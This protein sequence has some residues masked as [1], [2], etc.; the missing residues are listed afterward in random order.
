[1]SSDNRMPRL[2]ELDALRGVA[3]LCV[4]GF[5]YTF[6]LPRFVELET[7]PV[8]S[9][10]FGYF[11]VELFFMIS[12]FVILLTLEKTVSGA[13]FIVARFSRLYPVFWAACLT[14]FAIGVLAPLASQ[15]YTVGQ[16]IG[17]LTLMP[18]VFKI[19]EI[20]DVYWS[21]AYEI[22]FYAFMFGVFKLR[23]LHRIEMICAG[24]LL[25]SLIFM[26]QPRLLSHPLHYF[27]TINEYTHLFV[28]G[29]VMYRLRFAGVTAARI[30]LVLTAAG[31]A[32]I[33]L[34][35]NEALVDLAFMTVLA[36]AVFGRLPILRT[37][38]LLW[39]GAISY[40]LYLTHQLLGYRLVKR[41]TDFGAELNASII[42]AACIM[43]AFAAL[44]H[45]VVEQP[46][47]DFIR[48]RWRGRR[49]RH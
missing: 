26:W 39:F 43:L 41:L 22:G 25:A 28:F 46:A 12:G 14:T 31:V 10:A 38:L 2:V 13:D 18:A 36:A 19:A 30:A 29:L 24:L 16:L 21:L 47:Q 5:H 33:R 27:L 34:P 40:P 45:A 17:N 23:L 49:A 42:L 37:R 20:D 44:L 3:A 9:M 7:P 32:F 8:V 15:H 4:M 35:L 11:G 1:M 6:I 48:A